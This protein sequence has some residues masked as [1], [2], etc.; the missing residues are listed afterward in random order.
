MTHFDWALP[1]GHIQRHVHPQPVPKT[2]KALRVT[3]GAAVNV[4][5]E[6]VRVGAEKRG[7]GCMGEV[8]A[9]WFSW[10]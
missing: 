3:V 8:R 10:G 9:L 6:A 5:L 1:K 4:V 2:L 7:P